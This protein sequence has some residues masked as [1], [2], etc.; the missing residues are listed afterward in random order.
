ME[1][2]L[3]PLITV[4]LCW[5]YLS[6]SNKFCNQ[7]TSCP[8]SDRATYSACIVERAILDC[9]LDFQVIAPLLL[10]RHI[11][12]L[13]YDHHDL[14]RRHQ[15]IHQRYWSYCDNWRFL[16]K[17]CQNLWFQ[18]SIV[19]SF[20]VP[21]HVVNLD[22][23][24]RQLACSW[25]RLYW[26]WCYLQGI[27]VPQEVLKKNCFNFLHFDPDLCTTWCWDPMVFLHCWFR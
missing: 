14:H 1:L 12:M 22:W 4:G 19:V 9:V 25:W 24:C 27:E 20:S 6:S 5:G 2:S 21:W 7:H 11:L 17:W 16:N 23:Q 18:L 8:A 13:I 15:R 26:V 3:S 10:R